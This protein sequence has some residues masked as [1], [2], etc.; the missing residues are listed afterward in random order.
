MHGS[1]GINSP[2]PGAGSICG[3]PLGG[4]TLRSTS[5][6]YRAAVSLEDERSRTR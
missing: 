1:G 4:E 5:P 6:A 2:R 3:V